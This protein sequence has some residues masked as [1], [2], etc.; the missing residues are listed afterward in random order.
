MPAIVPATSSGGVAAAARGAR[1]RRPAPRRAAPS[2]RAPTPSGAARPASAARAPRRPSPTR[3][4]Q[5]EHRRVS[6]A[7][8]AC[9]GR[10]EASTPWRDLDRAC[11]ASTRKTGVPG[12]AARSVAPAACAPRIETT[13]FA[14]RRSRGHRREL[15]RLVG[16]DHEIGALGHLAVEATRLAAERAGERLRAAGAGVRARAR[17]RPSRARAP[18]PCSRADE[19]DHGADSSLRRS[20]TI[21]RECPRRSPAAAASTARSPSAP[22]RSR[23]GS[24]GSAARS[25]LGGVLWEI[26]AGAAASCASCAPPGA[27]LG[28]PEPACCAARGRRPRHGRAG[29]RRPPAPRRDAHGARAAP[30]GAELDARSD[31]R[32]AGDD[33]LAP[34]ARAASAS[35][36]RWATS[37]GCSAAGE[38][39]ASR[40]ADPE[41]PD[42]RRCVA[43]VLR[44]ARPPSDGGF[45]PATSRSPR[46]YLFLAP[47]AARRPSGCGGVTAPRRVERDQA[48]P[49]RGRSRAASARA[50]A[51]GGAGGGGRA[52][53]RRRRPARREPPSSSRR[54]RSTARSAYV[55]DPAVQ[56][57]ALRRPCV[58]GSAR[59]CPRRVSTG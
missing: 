14:R 33:R 13:R 58:R 23:P 9:V 37:S 28:L 3:P 12:Y 47:I 46:P 43:A 48:R 39:R 40:P 35:S 29:P 1:R 59:E 27:R 17:A 5:L 20:L 7:S 44:G 32:G 57:R 2:R 4:K 38:G 49:G 52:T 56:R 36:R 6:S 53:R 24:S 26:G 50:T 30:S 19:A 41:H 11:S 55:A 21:V 34:P 42:A 18:A 8:T 54:R 15:R 25:A 45:D 22:A 10:G 31:P 51:H 16:E